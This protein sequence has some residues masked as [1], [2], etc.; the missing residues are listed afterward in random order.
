MSAHEQHIFK[1]SHMKIE[2][3]VISWEDHALRISRISQVWSGPRPPQPFP[4]RSAMILL[5]IALAARRTGDTAVM[6]AILALSLLVWAFCRRSG[7]NTRLVNLGLSTGE[8]YSFVPANEDFS[9]Q[10]CL[11][12]TGLLAGNGPADYEISFQGDGAITAR[13]PPEPETE[14]EAGPQPTVLEADL[15]AGKDGQ[16]ISELQKLYRCYTNK[17]STGSQILDLINDT[18]RLIKLNDKEGVKAAFTKFITLGLV[19]DC[20]ELGLDSLLREIMTVLY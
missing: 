3:N 20:N 15:P 8:V 6:L 2:G 10:L 18:S 13:K 4:V 12:L 7:R 19:N 14:P 9:R 1:L 16:L 5:F 11:T 17:N